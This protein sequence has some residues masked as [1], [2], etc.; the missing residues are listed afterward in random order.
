MRRRHAHGPLP[1]TVS[2]SKTL[3]MVL[4]LLGLQHASR[5]DEAETERQV[6]LARGHAALRAMDC[7]RCHGRDYRGWAAPSLLAAVR[8]GSRERFER[9]VL[10]GDPVRGMP[11]Y[12]SQPLV[13]ADIDAIHAYLLALATCSAASPPGAAPASSACASVAGTRSRAARPEE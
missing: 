3:L 11:G 2:T 12:R 6:L 9:S 13:V 4:M 8:E 10:D 5:A 1:R 7:A